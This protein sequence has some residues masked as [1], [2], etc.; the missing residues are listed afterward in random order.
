MEPAALRSAYVLYRTPYSKHYV[1][2]TQYSTPLTYSSLTDVPLTGGYLIVPFE[3]DKT[4]PIIFLV[5]DQTEELPLKLP[6]L[7]EAAS[8]IETNEAEERTRY[9]QAFT[10]TAQLLKEKKLQKMVLS[11]RL[12]CTHLPHSD[13][14]QLFLKACHYRPN[15]FVALWSTPQTGTWLVATPEPIL[16]KHHHGWSTVALAG[17][18]PY[19][20][21]ETPTW[22]RKNREEQA[23]VAQYVR[24]RL[25]EFASNLQ[26]SETY[27]FRTG[28]IQ[29]LR[30]DFR[31][32]LSHETDVRN[33]L[34]RLHPTPAVCGLPCDDARRAIREIEPSPRRYYAGFSGP[35][36]L[37]GETRLFV[38]LRCMEIG[39]TTSTLYAGGG[40]MPE[41]HEADEWEETLRKLETMRTLYKGETGWG[42]CNS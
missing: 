3:I 35:F 27:S 40:I 26:I 23:I 16:E 8:G 31:F 28:N 36:F 17:T 42:N 4:T 2:L 37:H 21:G 18:I 7:G 22:S 19:K 32:P 30:T 1:K 5:P 25:E 15:N 6:E 10:A 11:R 13:A 41:S 24:T 34:A 29:H 33:L 14:E 12:N 38:S 9:A 20:E 39:D